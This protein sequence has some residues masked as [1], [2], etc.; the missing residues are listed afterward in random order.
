[1]SVYKSLTSATKD[2]ELDDLLYNLVNR[3]GP[4]PD[5]LINLIQESRLRLVASRVGICSL[6]RRPCGVVCSVE[7]RNESYYAF[8][9]LDYAEKFFNESNVK[10]HIVPTKRAVL[11]LCVH[12]ENNE[13]IYS[14]FSRFLGK[15]DALAKVN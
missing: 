14:L 13:D 4:I 1:M 10:Y 2:K 8:A 12:L 5:P 9:V 11:S 7:N 3:F 6:V 15:F